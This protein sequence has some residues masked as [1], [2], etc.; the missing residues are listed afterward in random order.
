MH[1]IHVQIVSPLCVF[2]VSHGVTDDLVYGVN[3]RS[4]DNHRK[5]THVLKKD[6]QNTTGLLIDET[7]DTLHATTTSETANGLPS[8]DR[9][10]K[11]QTER[12][13]NAYR[14]GNTLNVVTE[15]LAVALGTSPG[16]LVNVD[17]NAKCQTTYFPRPFPPFPRPD[18]G[19]K[20]CYLG[21]CD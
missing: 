14:L 16:P 5:M 6:L 11:R 1:S 10:Q 3:Y 4:R 7:R 21:V 12:G 13:N 19:E 9:N 15:N 2:S 17:Y 8:S 20:V 18:I